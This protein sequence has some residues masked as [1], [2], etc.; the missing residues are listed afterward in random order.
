MSPLIG[1]K[2][3]KIIVGISDNNLIFIVQTNDTNCYNLLIA[4]HNP[5]DAL[6][7]G[8]IFLFYF[9]IEPNVTPGGLFDKI[10]II[11]VFAASS[12]AAYCFKYFLGSF[13]GF[14]FRFPV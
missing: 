3:R 9:A 7:I 14:I 10:S 5:D 2:P 11:S 1:C 12:S 13:H 6:I 4:I 8:F